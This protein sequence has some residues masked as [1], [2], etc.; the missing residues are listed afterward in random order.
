MRQG[1]VLIVGASA[2]MHRRFGADQRA[3]GF[4]T[5]VISLRYAKAQEVAKTLGDALSSS[6][7]VVADAR[8]QSLIVTGGPDE[9][10]RARR[11][12]SR[13]DSSESEDGRHGTR[14]LALR[15]V[16]ASELVK[17]LKNVLP[18]GAYAADDRQNAVIVTGGAD[19][20]AHAQ[21]YVAQI[22]VPTPQVMFE[23]KVADIQP[24]NEQSNF[25]LEFGGL[26]LSGK[27]LR[28][29]TTYAFAARSLAVNARLNA[30][31]SSGHASILAT[32]KLVT[33]NNKE[34]TL[35][36]GQTYPVVYYDAHL[37][38]QQ[39]QFVDV[40]VKLR[41]TPTVGAD[42][43][44]TAELHPEYSAIQSFVSGYPVVANRRLDSTLRAFDNQ[45]IVIGG[46]LRDIDAE[47]ITKIPYLGDIPV[48]GKLFRNRDRLHERD[49]VV[50]LI[51]PHILRAGSNGR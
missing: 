33:L 28:G 30:L 6:S 45:T 32:P 17:E 29:A 18:D 16:R 47:T 15:H 36:I 26:D 7:I 51:T 46:L 27:P 12:A 14:A 21:A 25:G 10:R 40:G 8:T 22:D 39:V 34:A 2:A 50:F 24:E 11:L 23:V 19:V 42:G 31:V 4:Q 3:A 44:V 38:G 9:L 5:V 49:E 35:L 13:L 43:S 41:L 37:G 20:L 48:F 1:T